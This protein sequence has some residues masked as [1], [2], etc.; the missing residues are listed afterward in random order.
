MRVS[1]IKLMLYCNSTNLNTWVLDLF[2]LGGI[3]QQKILTCS[4]ASNWQS[5]LSLGS[6]CSNF[7]QGAWRLC[8]HKRIHKMFLYL[9]WIQCM[10]P[11]I[12]SQRNFIV[13][14]C[15]AVF[16]TQCAINQII[17]TFQCIMLHTH[18][19]KVLLIHC[20]LPYIYTNTL[21]TRSYIIN[22]STL[23]S[24]QMQFDLNL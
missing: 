3:T 14:G 20:V 6:W 17:F 24:P 2:I 18:Y 21:Y 11:I 15:F 5:S 23:P 1:S 9:L 8:F 16:H 4:L 19:C 7:T 13:P 22:H 10:V 12:Y